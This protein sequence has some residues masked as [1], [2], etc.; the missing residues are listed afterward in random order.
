MQL[1][2]LDFSFPSAL[3]ATEPSRPT[4]VAL[5]FS[6]HPPVET[7]IDGLLAHVRPEDLFV[8]NDS[9][10]VP[11]RV[12]S[13]EDVEILFL[14][15][16]D[17]T[18]WEVLFP[19]RPYKVGAVLHLPENIEARLE[20]K[21]L[22]Q[23]LRLSRAVD[24]SYFEKNGEMALPPYIQEAR[25]RRHNQES[26]LDWYQTAWA[27]TPGSVAAPTASLH[28][29]AEQIARLP[30]VVPV[31]LHVGAGTFFPVR[32]EDLSQHQMH[33]ERVSVPATLPAQMAATRARGG[34]V[35]ALGT[36]VARTLESM[37]RLRVEN[38]WLT[39]ETDIFIYPPYQF[40]NVDVLLT[41]FHQ[42]KSTLLALVSAFAGEVRVREA[43]QWAIERRFKLFSYG[44]LSAW[45]R[46]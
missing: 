1:S 13:R 30:Q 7:D 11:A 45:T 27:K 18:A 41:N 40:K 20:A 29:R 37:D 32:S 28:F 22:P 14:K 17:E 15:P 44:D 2:D 36:T 21:G 4:R 38:G 39:G 34:R 19:S 26:D 8:I 42:P 10:V 24:A 23:T 12:F 25:A 46:P 16:I 43:Y 9:K 31:T 6:G 5:N 35:W 3:I 33:S